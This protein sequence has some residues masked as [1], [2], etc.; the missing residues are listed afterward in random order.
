MLTTAKMMM[1]YS[2]TVDDICESVRAI[3]KYICVQIDT[4]FEI[5]KQKLLKERN[6]IE[7]DEKPSEESASYSST[8]E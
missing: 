6:Q 4:E 8:K 1:S 5:E 2:R 7:N 3:S